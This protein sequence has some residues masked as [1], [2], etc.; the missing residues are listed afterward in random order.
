MLN[1]SVHNNN[2]L[3]LSHLNTNC[4]SALYATLADKKEI[5]KQNYGCF[6]YDILLK[7]WT[8]FF[9]PVE[10]FKNNNIYNIFKNVVNEQLSNGIFYRGTD[11]DYYNLNVGD[12]IN[13]SQRLTSWSKKL[14]IAE[15]FTK[16]E[17]PLI[18]KIESDKLCALEIKDHKEEEIIMRECTLEIIYKENYRSGYLYTVKIKNYS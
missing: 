6:C 15:Q 10:E 16:F 3:G 11:Y 18:L 8:E 1:C 5:V 12:I 2:F 9:N 7:Q 4:E 13:Y 17:K 14:E